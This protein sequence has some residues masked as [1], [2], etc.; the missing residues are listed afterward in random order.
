MLFA[1][2]MVLKKNFETEIAEKIAKKLGYQFIFI[3]TS[4]KDQRRLFAQ[5]VFKK[6]LNFTDT[7]CNS[8]VLIDIGV[9]KKLYES[10]RISRNAVI[11]NGN[12]GDFI[13]GGHVFSRGLFKKKQ[14]IGHFLELIL[15]KHF[16]LWGLLKIRKNK[17]LIKDEINSIFSEIIKKNSLSRHKY[18]T[19]AESIEWYG[20]QSKWVTTTQRSYEFYGYEWRL[21]L[22]DPYFMNFWESVP[23]IFKENQSLYKEVLVEN[24]WGNVWK[25]IKINSFRLPYSILFYLRTLIK[26]LF[27]LVGKKYWKKFDRRVFSYFYDNTASTAIES[28]TNVLFDRNEAR[29]RNSWISKHYLYKKII[30]LI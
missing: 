14:T 3:Q 4:L 26:L 6:F 23:L 13:S 30:K 20:R 10:K 8:P 24:N 9:I 16:S 5:K 12:S 29:D 2:H 15:N 28:Y 27:I 7:L 21:P 22:W 18:W 17:N 25:D 11:I 19:I 1:F